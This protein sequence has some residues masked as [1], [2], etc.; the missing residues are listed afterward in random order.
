M[1][2]LRESV[3]EIMAKCEELPGERDYSTQL[4][5]TL[6]EGVHASCCSYT[7]ER[8]ENLRTTVVSNLQ[9]LELT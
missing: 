9:A 4:F 6:W 7:V 1:I 3:R 2:S 5:H 8:T